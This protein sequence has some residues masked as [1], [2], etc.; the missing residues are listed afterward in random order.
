MEELWQIAGLLFFSSIKFFLAPTTSV[1]AGYGFLSTVLITFFGAAI[2][3][4]IFFRFW[5]FI[6]LG[7][8]KVFKPKKKKKKTFSRKNKLIV[9]AKTTYGLIGIAILTP[10][11][12]GIPLGA[13]L[14]SNYYPNNKKVIPVFL[15]SILIWSVTLTYV[16]LYIKLP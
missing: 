11:L 6:K 14:A 15:S 7:I 3:F 1:I 16:S 8:Q 13:I 2:G 5:Q 10:C 9:R 4:V 12:L